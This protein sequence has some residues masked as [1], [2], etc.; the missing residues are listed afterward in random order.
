MD[1]TTRI[2][3]NDYIIHTQTYFT[4]MS[5]VSVY[6][7]SIYTCIIKNVIN[8]KWIFQENEENFLKN[9]KMG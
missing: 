6:I 4:N 3:N 9:E 2:K 5:Q 8:F 7:L 1:L